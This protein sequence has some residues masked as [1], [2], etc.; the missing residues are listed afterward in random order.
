MTPPPVPAAVPTP[1]ATEPQ[2]ECL[3]PGCHAVGDRTF[4]GRKK[5]FDDMTFRF[6]RE[7][8]MDAAMG[9]IRFGLRDEI[10]FEVT[11]DV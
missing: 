10:D 5:G 6:C 3:E 1:E 11:A 7:H 9:L 4:V 8:M 2:A